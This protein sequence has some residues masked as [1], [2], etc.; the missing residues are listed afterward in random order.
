MEL[1]YFFRTELKDLPVADSYLH[2]PEHALRRARKEI[3]RSSLPRIGV[4]CSAGE[5]N[6]SRCIP[7]DAMAPLLESTECQFWNLQGGESDPSGFQCDVMREAECCRDSI[8]MFAAV[9][10]Q[11]DLVI[12][13]DTLAAHLAGALGAPACYAA[14]AA[15][16]R[17]FR[18][19]LI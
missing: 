5:W 7:V 10:S 18:N 15:C 6:R 13:V 12:T 9:I 17:H 11:L 3:G 14:E 8:L 16:R 4:V 1:P 2:L 19:S